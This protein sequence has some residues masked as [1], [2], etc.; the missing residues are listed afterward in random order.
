VSHL[1][2]ILRVAQLSLLEK[3]VLKYLDGLA[4]ET[5]SSQTASKSTRTSR[6]AKPSTW[7]W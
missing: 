3:A 4:G 7:S 6:L 1:E 5:F 2:A